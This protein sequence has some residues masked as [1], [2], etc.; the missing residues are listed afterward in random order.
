MRQRTP[1][2]DLLWKDVGPPTAEELERYGDHPALRRLAD[3]LGRDDIPEELTK[4]VRA[5]R[6]SLMVDFLDSLA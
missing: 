1:N 6:T 5:A 2:D 4:V 3:E